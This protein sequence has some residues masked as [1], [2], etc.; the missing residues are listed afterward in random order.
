MLDSHS[1]LL[2]LRLKEDLKAENISFKRGWVEASKKL[3]LF[4]I[5]HFKFPQT[6]ICLYKKKLVVT[7]LKEQLFISTREQL[8]LHTIPFHVKRKGKAVFC[9]CLSRSR[10][11]TTVM[12][13]TALE[14]QAR[15]QNLI[16]K[17]TKS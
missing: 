16:K 7:T 6:V 4:Q 12:L 3:K 13:F 9:A 10:N 11:L 5:H 1:H 15:R 8:T 17:T 2:F 14:A